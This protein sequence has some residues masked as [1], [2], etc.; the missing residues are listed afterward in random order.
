MKPILAF[1]IVLLILAIA[2]VSLSLYFQH[3]IEKKYK[4]YQTRLNNLKI[5]ENET[6]SETKSN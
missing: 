5:D 1:S 3:R 4:E 2:Y 6:K